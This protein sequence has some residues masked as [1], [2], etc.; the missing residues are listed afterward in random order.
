ML[1]TC[2]VPSRAFCIFISINPL[3]QEAGSINYPYF[4][5]E[6]GKAQKDWHLP[7]VSESAVTELAAETLLMTP[8][9]HNVTLGLS[10]L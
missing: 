8:T 3:N 7:Q 4:A 2:Q 10:R 9:K 1:F 6:E 5:D